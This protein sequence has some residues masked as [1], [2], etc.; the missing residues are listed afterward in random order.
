MSRPFWCLVVLCDMGAC[1]QAHGKH[2]ADIPSSVPPGPLA[3][4]AARA[5]ERAQIF[6]DR[7]PA[8]LNLELDSGLWV[9]RSRCVRLQLLTC[10]H[11]SSRVAQTL[12]CC[13]AQELGQR[14]QAPRQTS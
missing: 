5:L 14:Q 2:G 3:D 6:Q 1:C 9:P 12:Q 7:F 11:V 10:T 13:A 8:L 4:S